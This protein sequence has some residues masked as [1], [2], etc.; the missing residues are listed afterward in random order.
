MQDICKLALELLHILKIVTTLD[1]TFTI[2]SESIKVVK[3][4][5]QFSLVLAGYL[6][7]VV[8]CQAK[9]SLSMMLA[10]HLC[11]S[12]VK[13]EAVGKEYLRYFP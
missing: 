11:F 9:N 2:L 7:M 4:L 8:N 13:S 12:F 3:L 5:E 6:N 1:Y 10:P